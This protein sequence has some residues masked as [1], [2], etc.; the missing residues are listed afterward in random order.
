MSRVAR[1]FSGGPSFCL[2]EPATLSSQICFPLFIFEA[3]GALL[4]SDMSLTLGGSC[5]RA[6][7]TGSYKCSQ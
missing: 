3:K 1:Q 5:L 7:V 4:I 2:S 6:P